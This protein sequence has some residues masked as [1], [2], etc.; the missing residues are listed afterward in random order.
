MPRFRIGIG[1]IMHEANGF[2]PSEAGLFHF[3]ELS[4]VVV[5]EE[6]LVGR[7]SRD[8]ITGFLQAI[9]STDEAIE[10]VPLINVNDFA[11]GNVSA[12]ALDY[13]E[14]AFRAG[15]RNSGD[16]DGILFALHGAMSSAHIP[17]GDG[18]LLQVV[19][20]EKGAAIPVVCSLDHHAVVTQQ[21]VDLS[22]ALVA[23]HTHPHID[24]VETGKRAGDILLAMLAG[25]VEPVLS[26]QKIPMA[27][28]PPDDG[29]NSGPLKELFDHLKTCSQLD[30]VLDCSLCPAY[31][32]QDVPEQGWAALVT[33]DGKPE[34]GTRLAKEIAA[35][36]W[37]A[38]RGLLP[39]PMLPPDE[40][41]RAA[42]SV[43][44]HPVIITD[45]ADT[46]GGGAPGDT[47][48]LLN[49]L[50]THRAKVDGLILVDLPDAEAVHEIAA[51]GTGTTVTLAVGGKG[52]TRFSQPLTVTGEVL[53]V[54]DG[55]IKD[56]GNFATTEF[57]D[58]GKIACLAIDN[59]RLVLTERII[60]GP[61]PSLFRKVGIE[62]FDAKIV[63]LKTGVGFKVTYAEAAAVFRANC[64]GSLSYDLSNFDYTK[65]P[66]PL[67]PLDPDMSWS[68]NE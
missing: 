8:E 51:A 14:K 7:E 67:Y 3:K 35:Q 45:S 29:T 42:A 2:S 22:S 68:V 10:L 12:E 17:D 39:E 54:T 25:K 18:Y 41:V 27:V 37:E 62:P 31:C 32:W 33:T 30:G 53:C 15:L 64:P 5:G 24:I 59:V 13:L 48:T 50:L 34:L 26:W 44:G 21:M 65:V 58:A 16:L 28:P 47:T 55:V 11:G 49:A 36:A 43:K 20:E 56:I 9:E 23:Y 46:T 40:A 60:I 6:V 38:R 52:D 57:V 61:Q 63:A 4:G 1:R 66:R 19:R